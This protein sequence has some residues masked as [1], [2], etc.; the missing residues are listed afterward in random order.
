MKICTKCKFPLPLSEFWNHPHCKN[1]KRSRCKKCLSA[2]NK[3]NVDPTGNRE[4]ARRWSALNPDKKRGS[5]L[6]RRYGISVSVYEEMF[7]KQDGKCAICLLP[8]LE[9][10]HLHVDHDHKTGKIRGLIHNK[11]NR[12][13]GFLNDNPDAF[14]RAAEYLENR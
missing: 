3:Q 13:L 2:E 8:P 11:C 1:G 4:R 6:R 12:A 14:R 7:D 5:N 9:G 10:K